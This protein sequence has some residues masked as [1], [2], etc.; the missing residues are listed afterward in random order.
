MGRRMYAI[1]GHNLAKYEF[2]NETNA[3][4]F[5]ALNY[6]FSTTY[7]SIL[8]MFIIYVQKPLKLKMDKNG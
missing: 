8:V 4:W 3:I 6:M 7:N 5:V 1:F 2:F